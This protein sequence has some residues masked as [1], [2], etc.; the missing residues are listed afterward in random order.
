MIADRFED[1]ITTVNGD[2]YKGQLRDAIGKAC[3]MDGSGVM[4]YVNGDEYEGEWEGGRKQGSGRMKYAD[5]TEYEGEWQSDVP[6][7]CGCLTHSNKDLYEGTF[8]DG[9]KHG[10]YFI[11]NSLTLNNKYPLTH[12]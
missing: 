11:N 10:L 8:R 7:G 6:N 9:C 2:K 5:G 12:Y 4:H 1:T 3:E